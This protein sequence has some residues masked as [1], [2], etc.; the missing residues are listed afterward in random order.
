MSPYDTPHENKPCLYSTIKP[1]LQMFLNHGIKGALSLR[2][3]V[4]YYFIYE[5]PCVANAIIEGK[6]S[7]EFATAFAPAVGCVFPPVY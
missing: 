2:I 3:S 1:F 7:I 5:I 4:I 6:S